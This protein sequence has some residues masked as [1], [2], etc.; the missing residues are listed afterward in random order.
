M[1]FIAVAIAFESDSPI[2]SSSS[3]E[4]R[5]RMASLSEPGHQ[6]TGLTRVPIQAGGTQLT[7]SLHTK[8]GVG[9][10]DCR[11]PPSCSALQTPFPLDT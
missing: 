9:D 3:I 8:C 4:L 2:N 7:G 5:Q 6:S 11:P 1:V 10:K